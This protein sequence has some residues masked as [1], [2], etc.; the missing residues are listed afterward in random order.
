V[1][2][3]ATPGSASPP[4]AGKGETA[5]EERRAEGRAASWAAEAWDALA[6]DDVAVHPPRLTS[7]AVAPL[8]P[9]PTTQPETLRIPYQRIW[10]DF[11]VADGTYTPEQ[12]RAAV[13][14]VKPW[15]SVQFPPLTWPGGSPQPLP[16]Q[17]MP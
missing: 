6:V 4:S 7:P 1:A 10:Y 14:V 8:G 9:V 13:L 15:G 3:T 2:R 17:G 11:A 12:L 5:E 16:R